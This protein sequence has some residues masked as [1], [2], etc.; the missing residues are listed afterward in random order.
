M[1]QLPPLM[2][3]R[4]RFL[5]VVASSTAAAAAAGCGRSTE[6]LLPYVIPPENLVP[7][8]ASWFS[9][10]CRECPAGCGVI[11]RNRD[12]RVVKLEGN[13][14]HPIN[15]GTLCIRG[16]AGLQ[17]LY[18]PDRIRGPLRRDEAGTLQP[19]PW[20]EAEGLLAERISALVGRQQGSRVAFLSQLETGSLGQ[21]MDQWVQSLGL[22]ERVTYEPFAYEAVRTANRLTFKRDAIPEYGFD[23]ARVVLSFGADFLETWL[24]PVAYS[25]AFARMHALRQGKA[26]TFIHVESRQSLT[27]A[28]ADEWVKNAPGTEG[29]LALAILRVILDEGLV[30]A[31]VDAAALVEAVK[32]VK[33]DAV[34]TESGVAVETIKHLAQSFAKARPSLAVGGGVAVSARNATQT[35]LAI[36]LLN[37]AVGNIGETVRFGPDSAFGKANPYRDVLALTRA[38]ARGEVEVL[39]L[40]HVNPLFMLPAKAGFAEALSKVPFVVS[41]ANQ[42][43]E[44]TALAH[45]VLPDPHWLEAWG[46]FSPREGVYGLIQP[47][48]ATVPDY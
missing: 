13:P 6:Q 8:V 12:G 20:E 4:R 33:L 23:Q 18:N 38:M 32:G 22:R 45:L 35:Q 44:T 42:L 28:N 34:A 36:N 17:G 14:D 1:H 9:T 40:A 11:A 46:D 19:I 10:V 24:S 25:G 39:L 37:Y 30:A 2:M 7:G 47:A 15:Q 27:A 41:F 26:G 43:D 5:K 29:N 21:L 16:Q 3:D 31:G 48:M